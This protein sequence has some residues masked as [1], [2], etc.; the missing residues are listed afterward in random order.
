MADE[1][2]VKLS[3]TEGCGDCGNRSVE[4]PAPLPEIGDDFD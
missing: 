2:Q 4:L 1:P 3:Y